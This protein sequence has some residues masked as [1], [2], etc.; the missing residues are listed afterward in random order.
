MS[1]AHASRRH[2]TLLCLLACAG[3]GTGRAQGRAAGPADAL[4][5]QVKAAYLY[6]FSSFV[7]WPPEAFASPESAL[8]I[9]VM[10]SDALAD[11]LVRTIA[12]RTIRGR[13]L[14]VRKLRRADATADLHLLFVGPLSRP[15]LGEVLAA[16]RRHPT[17]LVTQAEGALAQGS[18]VNLVLAEERL[19]FEIAPKAA[20]QSGLNISARLLA[21]ALKVEG[22]VPQ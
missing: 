12:G 13:P 18:M 17:L 2:W 20:E 22:K 1:R 10:E 15:Q 4:E 5:Q 11:Q 19:R 8:Q 7:E 6:N 9:G 21:A 14:A 16:A 3:T